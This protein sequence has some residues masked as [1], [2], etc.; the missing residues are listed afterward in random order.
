MAWFKVAEAVNLPTS[1]LTK[2]TA[3]GKQLCL[4]KTDKKLYAVSATCPHAGADLSKGRCED[5]KLVCPFHRYKYDLNT[6]RGEPGQ[7]DFIPTYAVEQRDDGIY[8]EVKSF[9][10]SFRSRF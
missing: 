4:V 5:G 6:G 10:E 3:G 8:V 2:V 9:F 1:F 7:N